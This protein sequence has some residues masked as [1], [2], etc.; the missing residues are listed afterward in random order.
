MRI[1]DWSSDVCSSD[2]PVPESLSYGQAAGLVQS[3]GTMLFSLTRRTKVEPGEW[4]LVLGA[5]GGIGL[6]AIDVA[7]HLGARVIAAASS[8]AK[9]ALADRKSTRLNSSH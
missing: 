1:S 6:A 8:D 9:L 3:Y 2:L 5:G 4:V 7:R